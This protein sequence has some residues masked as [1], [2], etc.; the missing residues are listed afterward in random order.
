MARVPAPLRS[1]TAS[2]TNRSPASIAMTLPV[3]E[4]SPSAGVAE[5]ARPRHAARVTVRI[6]R[7]QALWPCCQNALC[8]GTRSALPPREIRPVAVALD[9]VR[10]L[11]VGFL[12]RGTALLQ[13][14]AEELVAGTGVD[15]ERIA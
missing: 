13:D 15:R 8:A 12:F 4:S 9:E 5:P 6:L 2:P 14:P 10:E 11:P 1:P 7:I 3:A